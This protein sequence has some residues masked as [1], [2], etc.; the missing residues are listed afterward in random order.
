[1]RKSI[2]ILLLLLLTTILFLIS[3]SDND[4]SPPSD[5][6]EDP[7]SVTVRWETDKGTYFTST[8]MFLEGIIPRFNAGPED[9]DEFE[10]D[11]LLLFINDANSGDD[12]ILCNRPECS[13]DS[14]DCNAYLPYDS[15]SDAS[16]SRDIRRTSIIFVDGDHVYAH[17]AASRIFRFNLDGTG[18]EEAVRLPSKYNWITDG[19]LMNGKLYT[20]ATSYQTTGG[21]DVGIIVANVLIEIDYHN[22]TVRE[23]WVENSEENGYSSIFTIYEGIFYGI[24]RLAPF[25]FRGVFSND[26]EKLDY[27]TNIEYTLFSIDP[28]DDEAQVK[29]IRKGRGDEFNPCLRIYSAGDN[30]GIYYHSRRNEAVYLLDLI[31]GES[32]KVIENITGTMQITGLFGGR[33]FMFDFMK[34]TETGFRV[35]DDPITGVLHYD[36]TGKMHDAMF[37]VDLTTGEISPSQ[38]ITKRTLLCAILF[39]EGGYSGNTDGFTDIIYEKDGYFYIEI[40]RQERENDIWGNRRSIN[41]HLYRHLIGRIPIEDYWSGNVDAIEDLGWVGIEEFLEL[42]D[43]K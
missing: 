41:I 1:M 42:L 20:R 43:R 13:H 28:G 29:M 35:Y 14:M 5:F 36:E 31:T 4:K 16:R 24:E 15:F 38:I 27:H 32:V 17:N 18:R 40:E 8:P 22:G 10:G 23:L 9:Y 39:T 33:L 2:K 19:W 11:P 25:R 37:F 21:L 34:D 12:I 30:P 3:C 6:G 26:S 7:V